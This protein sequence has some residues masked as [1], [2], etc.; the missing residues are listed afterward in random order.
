[1]ADTGWDR[2]ATEF[3]S[4]DS[5]EC[6][7]QA[8]HSC[9]GPRPAGGANI[10]TCADAAAG[11]L[12][13]SLRTVGAL[14]VSL[15][16]AVNLTLL[17]TIRTSSK[18]HNI[19]NVLMALICTGN[20]VWC[21]T[22]ALTLLQ[23]RAALSAAAPRLCLARMAL[24]ETLTAARFGLLVTVTVIRYLIVVRNRS[25]RLTARAVLRFAGPPLA[26][27]L[28][29]GLVTVDSGRQRCRP[30]LAVTGAGLPVGAV[31]PLTG[32]APTLLLAAE[33]SAG[34]VLLTFCY[35]G[36]YT[37]TVRARRRVN[38]AQLPMR[39]TS[40]RRRRGSR[41]SVRAASVSGA[42]ASPVPPAARVL[43]RRVQS[44]PRSVRPI[45]HPERSAAPPRTL[46]PRELESQTGAAPWRSS[47]LLQLPAHPALAAPDDV[48]DLTETDH[49]LDSLGT[50]WL[51]EWVESSGVTR[52]GATLSPLLE[53]ASTEQTVAGATDILIVPS[54][55]GEPPPTEAICRTPSTAGE[56]SPP[57]LG[58]SR[59]PCR[60]PSRGPSR[61]S[62]RAPSRSTIRGPSRGPTLASSG[63]TSRQASVNSGDTQYS[64]SREPLRLE[65]APPPGRC[66]TAVAAATAAMLVMFVLSC[67][68]SLVG[69]LAAWRR[70]ACHVP[71]AEW[72]RAQIAYTAVDGTNAVLIPL[73]FVIFSRDFRQQL[74]SVCLWAAH[75]AVISPI[76]ACKRRCQGG[77]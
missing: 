77:E 26:A 41:R 25:F 45:P 10:T 69:E 44:L 60:G 1:M 36:I 49:P 11:E 51:E 31:P 76:T 5:D 14:M 73:V 20:L 63:G 2:A 52:L 6:P 24:Q 46:D 12:A 32:L 57:S 39:W 42:A 75:A 13:V 53:R 40:Q 17:L 66:D 33:Y 38:R 28:L 18:L 47:P 55:S 8:W 7:A 16:V 9:D 64:V 30:P 34:L 61:C 22:P 65:R 4:S 19:V 62:S 59:G 68:P 72:L 58:P 37:E 67:A 56:P 54:P 71:P 35:V 43:P 29:R 3:R 21:V 15:T 50:G 48:E 27:A 23:L 74:T 70:P